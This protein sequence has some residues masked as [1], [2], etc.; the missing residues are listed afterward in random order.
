M[1]RIKKMYIALIINVLTFGF[2][3]ASVPLKDRIEGFEP[4]YLSARYRAAELNKPCLVFVTEDDNKAASW[5]EEILFKDREVL[6]TINTHFI[7]GMINASDFD[8][9][10]VRNK[11][12]L[13]R[14]PSLAI[15]F[16][17][18][19]VKSLVNHGL[20]KDKFLEWTHFFI[21][22]N[23]A[24]KE[25]A[26]EDNNFE[27]TV[28]NW[29]GG[30]VKNTVIQHKQSEPLIKE[31]Q[32]SDS[33]KSAPISTFHPNNQASAGTN[34]LPAEKEFSASETKANQKA[35][36]KEAMYILQAGVF[37]AENN[38]T[39]LVKKLNLVGYNEA[40][41]ESINV[42]GKAMYK[43]LV[44]K[45]SS[46]AEANNISQQLSAKGFSAIVKKNN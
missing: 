32:K 1:F 2:L 42:S 29:Q 34:E 14:S 20:T 39:A 28:A 46:E 7:A 15:I 6:S 13:S 17:D 26:P 30:T 25:F 22:L 23:N 27:N 40:F 31:Q 21:D 33:P 4:T 10:I 38:A 8:G 35:T 19:K 9:T 18:G 41:I 3:L 16:P 45:Y 43:V 37:G 12:G 5:M 36:A 44:G 11:L 24:G